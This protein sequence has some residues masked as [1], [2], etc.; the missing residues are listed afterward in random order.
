MFLLENALQN[1]NDFDSRQSI[2]GEM[3][4]SPAGE[5]TTTMMGPLKEYTKV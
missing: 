2:S 1:S 3:M 4:E 5:A